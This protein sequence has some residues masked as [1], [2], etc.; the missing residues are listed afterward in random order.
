MIFPS[1]QGPSRWP[2]GLKHRIVLGI[3]SGDVI[4]N[5]GGTILGVEPYSVEAKYSHLL[6]RH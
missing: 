3:Q 1:P 4:K 5:L 2:H 6:L